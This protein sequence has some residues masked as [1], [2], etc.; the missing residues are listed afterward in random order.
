MNS[1]EV[2]K[3]EEL[4]QEQLAAVLATEGPVRLMAGP[5]TGKTKTLT[6]RFC[7]LVKELG[8][9]PQAIV[10]A[11]F[12]N[13]A[14][15]EMKSRIRQQI[16]DLDLGRIST[17]HSLGLNFLKEEISV[18]GFPKNF[19]VLNT[20]DQKTL[21]QKIF[22]DMNLKLADFTIQAALDQVLEAG[23]LY[24]DDYVHLFKQNDNEPI[25]LSFNQAGDIK[26]QIFLRYIYEQ[27][28]NFGLD[29]N[30]LINLTILILEE[31][32][33]IRDKWQKLIEYVMVDEFQDVS[34]RQYR[35]AALLA[36][37][38]QNLFIVGDPDQTIYSWRG[39]HEKLFY[40]FTTVHPKA[41]NLF[42]TLNYRS[43]PEILAAAGAVV[44]RNP[45]R[46]P[47]TLRAL[48]P[49]GPKPVYFR[50]KTIKDEADWI[51]NEVKRLSEEGVEFSQIAVIYRAHH[52]SRAVEESFVKG[53]VPYRLFSGVEFYN[54][55]EIKDM[56]CYLRL[57]VFGDDIS[58]KRVINSPR[59]KIG[60]KTL[61]LLDSLATN[62]E[63][64]LYDALKNNLHLFKTTLAIR[65][66]RCVEE[67]RA[68]L[69]QLSFGDLF[70]KLM[71][72]SGY[73]TYLRTQG[74]QERLDN[75]S[76]LKRAIAAFGE[77]PEA[78]AADF[79]NQAALFSNLDRD[80]PDQTVKLATIHAAKGLEF[81][82]VF[83]CGLSEGILPSRKALTEDDLAEERRLCYVAMT[84]AKK[85]LF[86]SDAAALSNQGLFKQPSR[87]LF[88][89]GQSLID[90]L[91]KPD[92]FALS[93]Q[94]LPQNP[95]KADFAPGDRVNHA[96]FGQ[97]VVLEVDWA[98]SAYLIQFDS[99]PT[100]RT[101]RFLAPLT[102][103]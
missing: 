15:M 72:L 34:K 47:Y 55:R 6:Q 76:E 73:E 90:F 67:I 82:A 64:S 2:E 58:L 12:T 27:K 45:G 102:K 8:V 99:L 11:T 20:D 25:R 29:F 83:L 92:S 7:H 62:Q 68:D 61:N 5:G 42:L 28:K 31:Y 79:L 98:R 4:N 52:Q 38:H 88:E 48:N 36:G 74:D 40:D 54:R 81:E 24:G 41:Q 32:S 66:V 95:D 57:V 3:V 65:L 33:D 22:D 39:A 86:L 35:L 10:C 63:T 97:G 16:G 30:D 91:V 100:T 9:S 59:R 18:L 50:G 69:G 17:L 103:A 77:D 37:Y 80:S 19:I 101:L 53:Q 93:N 49:S 60:K 14:A 94:L 78:T 51:R 44:A 21:L 43:T 96:F 71:D 70:Q 46:P 87:F 26:K 1:Y 89:A 13:R 84:R 75:A 23:K 85:R 56:I